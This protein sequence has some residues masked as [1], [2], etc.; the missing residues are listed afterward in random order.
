VSEASEGRRATVPARRGSAV[1][2]GRS[3]VRQ[4]GLTG[5]AAMVAVLSGLLLDVT[6]AARFG[7][8]QDTDA[9]VVAA[10]LPLTFLAM[11]IATANQA[12]VPAFSAWMVRFS[13][14]H[15]TRLV[16]TFLLVVW[17]VSGALAAVLA[18]LADPLVHVLAPGF[19]E[20][21]KALA[22]DLARVMVVVVPL[23]ASSEVLRAY[24]NA[25][26]SFVMPAAMTVVL[27]SVS[28]VVILSFPADIRI[29]PIAYVAG[30]SAQFLV[31]L[32]AAWRKGLRLRP[33]AGLRH[34]EVVRTAKLCA[35]P[36]AASGLNPLARMVELLFASFLPA[37]S[38]TILHYGNRLISAVGGTVLFRSVTVAVL[39]RLTRAV[40]QGREGDAAR[41]T[42][43]GARILISLS[44]ALT[45]LMVALAEPGARL[46]F[47]RGRFDAEAATLLGIVLVAY[48]GS[49][50][51]SA[52]QRALLSPF[53]ARMD[54][55]TPL[56]NTIY[57]VGSNL[58]LIPVMIYVSGEGDDAVVA[59]AIAYSLSQY[60]HVA[61]IWWRLRRTW[62]ID[63]RPV[64]RA[65]LRSMAGSAVA[66]A[67]MLAFAE[68]LGLYRSPGMPVLVGGVVVTA[69]AG[70]TIILLAEGLGGNAPLREL[71]RLRGGRGGAGAGTGRA[72]G[73]EGGAQDTATEA[74][75]ATGVTANP[76][77]TAAGAT[78]DPAAGAA[79]VGGAAAGTEVA[80]R[81]HQGTHAPGRRGHRRGRHVAGAPAEATYPWSP[82]APTVEQQLGTPPESPPWGTISGSRSD[83]SAAGPRG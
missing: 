36:L 82:A 40:A 7:A 18:A 1:G 3:V 47:Q 59:V 23:T 78:A 72:A 63:L 10:R 27:N 70:M 39:P 75:A 52:I 4:S 21:T 73:G 26:L 49:L 64:R 55:V 58:L 20:P 5:V 12:L 54:T 35:R 37:G 16:S 65:I 81:P 61:H 53:Y 66:T 28:I 9:F 32:V 60:V 43:V 50:V 30:Q 56:R 69:A 33:T 29:V 6:V 14:D 38:A 79:A 8:G 44:F 46:L 67:V 19:D 13:R 57:G 34:P 74:T 41:L 11:L 80:T 83:A 48:A 31:M 71:R 51:G 24:L 25:R 2:G 77:G 68:V 15:T 42:V 76:A 22:T 45:A 17:L 62:P